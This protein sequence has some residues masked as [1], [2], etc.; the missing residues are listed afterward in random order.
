LAIESYYNYYGEAF[1]MGPYSVSTYVYVIEFER[2][3]ILEGF[4]SWLFFAVMSSMSISQ[5]SFEFVHIIE[6]V[7]PGF[8]S[9]ENETFIHFYCIYGFISISL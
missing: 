6:K 9:S 5:F 4:Q 3:M 1:C 8:P 7:K 2:G